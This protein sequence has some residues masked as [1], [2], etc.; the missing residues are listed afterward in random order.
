MFTKEIVI[1]S[2]SC[3]SKPVWISFHCW[4]WDTLK[5]VWEKYY[6]SQS[7]Q[8]SSKYHLLCSAEERNAFRFGTTLGWVSDDNFNLCFIPSMCVHPPPPFLK[9][10][11]GSVLPPCGWTNKWVWKR[12]SDR[13]CAWNQ[14]LSYY[15]VHKQQ[16]HVQ[17]SLYSI[18]GRWKST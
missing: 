17:N 9:W 1:Y 7:H 5:N 8:H 10:W 2:P 16:Y 15:I 4:T 6:E 11:V 18:N 14:I 13:Y 3:S 12:L